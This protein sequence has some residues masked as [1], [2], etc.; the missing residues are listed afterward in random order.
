M[1]KHGV[2]T[3]SLLALHKL[4]V[5][6]STSIELKEEMAW[7]G[8]LHVTLSYLCYHLCV[9]IGGHICWPSYVVLYS[10]LQDFV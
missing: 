7:D 1:H 5:S 3:S 9:I 4:A 8:E 6:I 10:L 2:C